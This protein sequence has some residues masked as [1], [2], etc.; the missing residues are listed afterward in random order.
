MLFVG[1]DREVMTASLRWARV[2]ELEKKRKMADV[3]EGGNVEK[4]RED[5]DLGVDSSEH[6]SGDVFVAWGMVLVQEDLKVVRARNQILMMH[7]MK[8]RSFK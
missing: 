6:G 2:A 5:D 7:V 8:K 3:V 1:K 4:N